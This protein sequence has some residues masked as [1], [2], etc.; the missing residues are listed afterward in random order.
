MRVIGWKHSHPPGQ[1]HLA[2]KVRG[3]LICSG[4]YIIENT[5]AVLFKM[6]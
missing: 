1:P 2:E 4:K 3:D 5:A 6:G